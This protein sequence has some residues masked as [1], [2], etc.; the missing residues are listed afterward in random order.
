M[1]LKE[2]ENFKAS[3][4]KIEIVDIAKDI[5]S[6]RS[7]S[8][9]GEENTWAILMDSALLGLKRGFFLILTG[10]FSG[11][12][13]TDSLRDFAFG[14][15]CG[16]A[17]T[18]ISLKRLSSAFGYLLW[19]PSVLLERSFPRLSQRLSVLVDKPRNLAASRIVK[20]C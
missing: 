2:G 13:I 16:F 19:P 11:I 12:L 10:R 18:S 20:Y 14:K 4:S 3:S 6:T 17:W 9:F 1:L 7:R 5:L 15:L 8:E